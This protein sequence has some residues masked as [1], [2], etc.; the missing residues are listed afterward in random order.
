MYD[1]VTCYACDKED[2]GPLCGRCFRTVSKERREEIKKEFN[3]DVWRG[4]HAPSFQYFCGVRG[5]WGRTNK[6]PFLAVDEHRCFFHMSKA[7]DRSRS[8]K[9]PRGTSSASTLAPRMSAAIATL[10]AGV[11]MIEKGINELDHL[12]QNPKLIVDPEVADGTDVADVASSSAAG[13]DAA[14]VVIR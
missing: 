14:V 3:A 2:D 12:Q 10:R 5:C 11:K 8:P 6:K 1:R 13:V 9:G 4:V 7:A